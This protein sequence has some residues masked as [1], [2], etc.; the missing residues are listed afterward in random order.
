VAVA[1]AFAGG[2]GAARTV[3][4]ARPIRTV[5]SSEKGTVTSTNWSG[6]AAFG[7]GTTFSEAKGTWVQPAVVCATTRNQYASF[8][9]GL[10][11]FNSNS[12]EQTGTDSDCSHRRPVYYAWYEMYPAAPVHLALE[13]H[14]GDTISADVSASGST[15]TL[16]I[17]NVTTGASFSTVQAGSAARTSAEWVAEAPSSCSIFG[18]TILPLANFGTVAFSGSYAT[19]NGHAGSIGDA[20]WQNDRIIMTTNGGTAKATPAA[21]SA[22]GTSFTDTWSHS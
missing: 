15:V 14:P 17:R 3:T 19:G 13:I 16:T 20:A 5:A 9:V 21:L 7:T 8:W 1:G 4:S 2:S 10:D 22:D 6:Y 18:C 12:V 11:G